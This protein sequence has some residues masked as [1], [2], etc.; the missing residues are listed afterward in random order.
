[1][2]SRCQHFGDKQPLIAA[3]MRVSIS[4]WAAIGVASASG[5]GADVTL[6]EAA[7]G[8]GS[9]RLGYGASSAALLEAVRLV[10][11]HACPAAGRPPP[12][13]SSRLRQFER[14]HDDLGPPAC[15]VV[16][17][18]KKMFLENTAS[19]NEQL[20]G[21][22]RGRFGTLKETLLASPTGFSSSSRA[23]RN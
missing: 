19:L 13:P 5:G 14:G 12:P 1:M 7:L 22:S 4:S 3:V 8:P 20:L 15:R 16:I 6:G 18:G 9:E 21:E 10:G 17:V 23:S 11:L 2:V